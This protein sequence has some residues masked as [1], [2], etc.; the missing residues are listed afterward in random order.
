MSQFSI[1]VVTA[2]VCIAG[3]MACAPKEDKKF[4]LVPGS[5]SGITFKNVL[6]ETVEFNI[7]NYMYFYNGG[8]VAAGDVNGDELPDIYFTSNQEDNKLYIN[9]G[10]F[11]FADVTESAGVEGF[12]GWTTGVTMVDVNSDG[13]L[14][15][16]VSNLGDYLIYKGKNQLFIN[17]GNDANG[18]PKFTDRAMEYGLD[19]VGFSTQ[20]SFFDYD[21]DGDLDMFML[22]HSLHENGTFGKSGLRTKNHPL[23]GDRLLRNDNGRFIDV[24]QGSGIYNSVLGY[25]LGVVVS[26]VNLDGWPDIYVGNDFHEND[27]LYINQGNGTFREVLEKSMMHTSRY[28]MGVD[29]ADF[30][31]D[32]YPDLIAM[33]MLPEDPQVLKA[34]AAEDTY[35]VYNFKINY[36][37]NHQFARNTLQLNNQDGTFSEIGLMSGVA[38]TDWSWSSLFADF[39]LDGRKDIFVSNGILRRSNDLDYI[40]FITIDSVQMRMKYDMSERELMYIEKLPKIK[41]PN[42]LFINN[43]D[44]TFA[45]QALNWGLEAPSYSNGTAYAD[46]DNDGDLDLVINNIEDEAFVYENRTI[47]KPVQEN[48]ELPHY[49]QVVLAGDVG[50][51]Q[52]IGA[53]VF[54]YTLG[55]LQMQECMP[56][57]G[58]QSSVDTKLTFGLGKS[59]QIDSLVVVWNDGKFE[60]QVNIQADQKLVLKQQ[61]AKGKFSYTG[62]HKPQHL[63]VKDSTAVNIPYKH[64]ENRF[65]EFN[66]EALLPHMLSAEGPAAVTG[67]MNGDGRED[68]FLGNAKWSKAQVYLQTATGKFVEQQQPALATDSTYEDVDAALLDADKDGDLD[69]LVVSGGNEFTGKSIYR[70]PRLYLNNGKAVFT[71]SPALTDIYMT[72]SC[73]SVQD[74]DADGDADIFLGA[75]ANP[76]RYGLKPDSYILLNDGK[77]NFTDAT[78][79][80]APVLRKFG[81]IKQATWADMDGDKVADLV[82]AAEWSPITIL[83]NKNGKLAPIPLE[84]SGLEKSNGWW[85]IVQAADFDQ[86]GDLDLIAGNLGLNSRLHASEQEPVKMFVADFDKNDSTDQVL[87][88]FIHGKEYPFHTRDEMT[89]QMP[90]LKKRYL[91]YHKFA[92]ATVH[93]MFTDDVL[94]ASEKYIAYNFRTCYI[95]NTGQGKFKIHPLPNAAQISTVNAILVDDFNNDKK[96]DVLLAGNFYPI[97]I[98]MGRNDASYGLLF[99]GDGKGHFH[100]VPAIQSGFSVTGETHCLKIIHVNGKV[101]YIAVRNNDTL[102]TFGLGNGVVNNSK[103]VP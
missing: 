24:T 39:D 50:N 103:I 23:A 57:R 22:N 14:D 97:N 4:R 90:Y 62:F 91:S 96:P 46:F 27:Y 86:D 33:D 76:W 45:N 95:E 6:K 65:V 44:S 81:F 32:A 13:K 75:R 70:Q 64:T 79:A 9:K 59:K 54:I 82:I 77:G 10:N 56:T 17:E 88:H 61:N 29:F 92:E 67:D 28:T 34:S 84:G 2:I 16:Y 94:N 43:G 8:G 5:E 15:I 48:E 73:V 83:L 99:T 3:V 68:I 85:N 93:D 100:T 72:G 55:T 37:Y 20:A 38:A 7:F 30:N 69:L 102:V 60:K 63:L 71:R 26:D 41:V 36:G 66:R 78:D 51:S 58:Y 47:H 49:L 80:V 35:D 21:R 74:I 52:G 40:N 31:N 19:L 25:G 18:I 98:Q 11:K 53:K 12:K 42:Y 101:Y 89:K 1:K 87:T